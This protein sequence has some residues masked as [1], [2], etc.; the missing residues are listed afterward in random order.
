M[1]KCNPFPFF[2]HVQ[3]VHSSYLTEQ[4]ARILI[5]T[6]C[7][8]YISQVPRLPLRFSTL[9]DSMQLLHL[10]NASIYVNSSLIPRLSPHVNKRKG[11]SLVKFIM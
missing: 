2:V 3:T 10:L 4:V 8:C 1:E 7:L 11:E 5:K 6:H 9:K